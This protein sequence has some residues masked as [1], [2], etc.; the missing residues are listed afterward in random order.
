MRRGSI[1]M[2]VVALAALAATAAQAQRRGGRGGREREQR[3]TPRVAEP[4]APNPTIV[5]LMNG[6][7]WGMSRDEVVTF[8]KGQ[9]REKYWPQIRSLA[10]D[11]VAE[12]NVRSRMEREQQ[13]FEGSCVRFDG[14]QTPWDVSMI[15][16]EFTH[17]NQEEM[18]R[19]DMG[20]H[21]DHLFFIRGKL[22]K[23]FRSLSAGPLA[24]APPSFDDMRARMEGEFGPGEDV[25]KVNPYLLVSEL[26]GIRWID[27][28]TEMRLM[29]FDLYGIFSIV[30]TERAT[31]GNLANLRTVTRQA[32]DD[33]GTRRLIEG[34]T[35]GSTTNENADVVQRLTG[36]RPDTT[37]PQPQPQPQ[38]PAPRP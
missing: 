38:P 30:L 1:S 18:C 10:N 8:V 4:T 19:L 37:A 28:Q 16:G 5:A 34:V 9:I 23:I 32:P 2:T 35:T 7:T 14:Q 27:S 29:W 3:A 36:S 15:D 25:R 26:I 6:L 22:W 24:E 20:T 33:S 12:H 17:R 31:L 13:A 11:A 21:T